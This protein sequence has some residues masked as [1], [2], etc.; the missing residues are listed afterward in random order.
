MKELNTLDQLPVKGE[1]N[2]I[3]ELNQ[4]KAMM[5]KKGRKE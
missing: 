5:K 1:E 3:G 4:I 2:R